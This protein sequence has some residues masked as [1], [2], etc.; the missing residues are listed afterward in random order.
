M[1]GA[2]PHG[3]G[4]RR[5]L[6]RALFGLGVLGGT[7]AALTPLVRADRASG[8]DPAAAPAAGPPAGGEAEVPAGP[9]TEETYR[10]RHIRVRHTA[11][12]PVRAGAL[13]P[14]VY[15]GV[16]SYDV[17][18]DGRP[19]PVMRRADGSYMSAV[20]HYES[21]PTLVAAAR[22]AVDDLRGARLALDDPMLHHA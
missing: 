6:L 2:V 5:T 12:G 9:V 13:S 16:P 22:A 14:G 7:A 10:G 3:G 8:A 4:T 1:A 17:L 18:I 11:S 19:L 20:N 21:F 15:P